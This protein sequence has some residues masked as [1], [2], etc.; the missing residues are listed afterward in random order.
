MKTCLHCGKQFNEKRKTQKY[1]SLEC[2]RKASKKGK[3]IICSVCGKEFYRKNAELKN[4]KTAHCSVSCASK[5]TKNRLG[6]KVETTTKC[7]T[8]GKEFDHNPN[9]NRKFCSS[10]CEKTRSD[11]NVGRSQ[12][13]LSNLFEKHIGEIAENEFRFDD[14]KYKKK[15]PI[16]IIFNKAKIAIE[17]NGPHHY[18]ENVGYTQVSLDEQKIKDEIKKNY[19]IDNEYTFIEWPYWI[20]ISKNNVLNVLGLISSQAHQSFIKVDEKVQRLGV[21]ENN[22]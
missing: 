21:E 14:L 11:R 1:C 4:R 15:L 17:F 10:I 8:C 12:Q 13:L 2:S 6:T 7:E 16:D 22:Q 19:L 18:E 9:I 3:T 5:M 20:S